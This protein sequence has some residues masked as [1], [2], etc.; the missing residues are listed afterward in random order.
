MSEVEMRNLAREEERANHGN[1]AS[2]GPVNYERLLPDNARARSEEQRRTGSAQVSESN[3]L[4]G[5]MQGDLGER[6][7]GGSQQGQQL[8]AARAPDPYQDLNDVRT[9][10]NPY[11]AP[12]SRL[13]GFTGVQ[14]LPPATVKEVVP[15]IEA[16]D[17]ANKAVNQDRGKQSWY[18]RHRTGAA[19]LS[20]FGGAA[21]WGGLATGIWALV[22][23][24]APP[25]AVDDDIDVDFKPGDI[26]SYDVVSNDIP[27]PMVDKT[28]VALVGADGLDGK[29]KTVAGVGVWTAS[30]AGGVITFTPDSA[31]AVLPAG[32]VSVEY[33]VNSLKGKTSNVATLTFRQKGDATATA[34]PAPGTTPAGGTTAMPGTT[35]AGGTTPV[36]GTTPAGGTT[37]APG[38]TPVGGTTPAPRTTPAPTTTPAGGTTASPVPSIMDFFQ[39]VKP[40]STFKIDFNT[41]IQSLASMNLSAGSVRLVGAGNANVTSLTIPGAGTFDVSAATPGV[42]NFTPVSG[43]TGYPAPVKFTIANNAMV[44]SAPFQVSFQ[45]IVI[46]IAKDVAVQ[47][48][49][50]AIDFDARTATAGQQPPDI[51]E[52]FVDTTIVVIGTLAMPGSAVPGGLPLAANSVELIGPVSM[53]GSLPTYQFVPAN[54]RTKLSVD[55][56]GTWTATATGNIEFRSAKNF[57]R[58]PTPVAY[59]VKDTDGNISKPGTISINPELRTLQNGIENFLTKT[60]DAFWAEFATEVINNASIPNDGSGLR[61]IRLIVHTLWATINATFSTTTR[62]QIYAAPRYL[63]HDYQDIKMKWITAKTSKAGLLSATAEVTNTLTLLQAIPLATRMI[64][65]EIIRRLITEMFPPSAN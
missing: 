28:S 50:P 11:A 6:Q 12:D 58:W 7:T 14:Q 29:T 61:Q 4:V 31:L 24:L 49:L 15:K 8:P 27:S 20:F 19:T 45:G 46:P 43:F 25:Y 22:D 17:K 26:L 33:T 65:L 38:T 55:G 1:D 36:P 51:A 41:V 30:T 2:R 23:N 54:L 52:G 42:V 60:D 48:S 13:G 59:T 10:E 37:P 39:V 34:K 40:G 53:D 47:D 9:P 57:I 62:T 32:G 44:R 21:L 16:T 35:P 3:R 56:E 18:E 64:R 63:E 5:Q